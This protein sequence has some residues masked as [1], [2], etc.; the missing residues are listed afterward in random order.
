MSVAPIYLIY[1]EADL[2]AA[3]ASALEAHYP[4]VRI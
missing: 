2:G 1:A 3:I 4:S